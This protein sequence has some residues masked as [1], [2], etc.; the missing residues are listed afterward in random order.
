MDKFWMV[1]VD[2]TRLTSHQHA[3]FDIARQ[4]AERLLRLP[5]NIVSGRGVTILEAVFYGTIEASP[6]RWEVIEDEPAA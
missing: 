1:L 5:E 4:E 6:V 2:G 3:S